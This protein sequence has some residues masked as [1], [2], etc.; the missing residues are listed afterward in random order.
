M[1]LAP[2]VTPTLT[3]RPAAS[4]PAWGRNSLMPLLG[5]DELTLLIDACQP[6]SSSPTLD[7]GLVCLWRR[8]LELFFLVFWQSI[9]G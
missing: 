5:R 3:N 6:L 1:P 9:S 2:W 8:V 4:L 7:T